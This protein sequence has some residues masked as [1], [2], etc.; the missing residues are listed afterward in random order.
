ML[1][2][3]FNILSELLVADLGGVNH[4]SISRLDLYLKI[5]SELLAADLGGQLS[6]HLQAGSSL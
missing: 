5:L 1:D 2:L 4:L 6:F 3:H